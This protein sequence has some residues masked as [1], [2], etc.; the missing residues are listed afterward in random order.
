MPSFLSG[1]TAPQ[2]AQPA[3]FLRWPA[4]L[5]RFL[6]YVALFLGL[7]AV[8]GFVTYGIIQLSGGAAE[9]TVDD[10]G[11]YYGASSGSYS[12][13]LP[14][15]S[16]NLTPILQV[17]GLVLA[18]GILIL[19]WS[20]AYSYTVKLVEWLAEKTTLARW[21]VE[22]GLLLIGWTVAIIATALWLPEQ[23][24]WLVWCEVGI[25]MVGAVGFGLTRLLVRDYFD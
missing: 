14:M 15:I 19:F 11:D 3:W 8:L 24:P 4:A 10:S 16:A 7:M 5:T 17:V 21:T 18:A 13:V 2:P 25:L 12:W 22:I 1:K 9:R 6:A 20:L 23:V